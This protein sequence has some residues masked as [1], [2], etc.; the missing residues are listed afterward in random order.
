MFDYGYDDSF[1]TS[2]IENKVSF[3]ISIKGYWIGIGK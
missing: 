1:G 3:A 2:I